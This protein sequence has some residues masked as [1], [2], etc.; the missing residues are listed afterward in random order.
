MTKY[1]RCI[2][3]S[4]ESNTLTL[5]KIYKIINQ[6]S[7]Y[8]WIINDNGKENNYYQ[9]LFEEVDESEVEEMKEESITK[10]VKCINI[11]NNPDGLSLG[12]N[13]EFLE[14]VNGFYC[15]I[16]DDGSKCS[17]YKNR[18]EKVEAPNTE[19]VKE[20]SITKYVKCNSIVDARNLTFGKVYELI[21]KVGGLCRIINDNGEQAI[22]S[23]D[24]FKEVN[25]KSS[26]ESKP[27]YKFVPN[28][29]LIPAI[30]NGVDGVLIKQ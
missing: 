28:S 18:F 22:Y 30:V 29:E 5:N 13:Y 9:N 2:D 12:E 27:V 8:Y 15:I 11:F 20:E 23:S 17:Y 10:Y 1:V 19:Q 16:N 14:E 3:N 7:Y 25:E 24:R 21:D 26:D 4:G 6:Y